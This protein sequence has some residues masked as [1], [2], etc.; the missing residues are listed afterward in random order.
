[1]PEIEGT[2]EN[3]LTHDDYKA[4]ISDQNNPEAKL[5]RLHYRVLKTQGS[6][7]SLVEIHLETGRYHQIRAQCA[8]IRFSLRER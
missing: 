7:F 8:A 4:I 5:A 3:Y 6:V 1:M 2:L